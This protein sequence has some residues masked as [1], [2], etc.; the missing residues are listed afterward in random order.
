MGGQRLGAPNG[1]HP[2]ALQGVALWVFPIT[3]VTDAGGSA[4][5]VQ[6]HIALAPLLLFRQVDPDRRG[7]GRG[8]RA[9][10]RAPAHARS[11][12]NMHGHE[13]VITTGAQ[14]CRHMCGDAGAQMR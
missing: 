3:I 13:G 9:V 4:T 6:E 14:A 12:I 8:R 11:G 2:P 7:R 5:V 1:D 10:T